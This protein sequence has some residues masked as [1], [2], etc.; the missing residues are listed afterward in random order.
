LWFVVPRGTV[1]VR[2]PMKTSAVLG[3]AATLVLAATAAQAQF[4]QVPAPSTGTAPGVSVAVA[5]TDYKKDAARHVYA[6]YP[7]RVYRGKL[8]PLLFGV[9]ITE[10]R[11]DETG[12]VLD[13]SVVRPPAAKE[14]APWVVEL[15]KR[16]S[17]FPAP[18]RLGAVSVKE[19]WLVDKSGLFQVD[20]LTEG[21]R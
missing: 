16:A 5:E 12:A 18:S 20:S 11:L 15:I 10:T 7:M 2:K 4:Q 8:P 9:M 21:Q 1:K 17:P 6:S 19:I 14:V 3:F 13:V